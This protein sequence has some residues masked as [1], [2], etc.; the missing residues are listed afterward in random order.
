[1]LFSWNPMHRHV[2]LHDHGFVY[3]AILN[4][5]DEP[6]GVIIGQGKTLPDSAIA[7]T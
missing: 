3:N 1:M 6:E 5:N 4:W 2:N 7:R